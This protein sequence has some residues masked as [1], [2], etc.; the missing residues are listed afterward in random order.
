[1]ECMSNVQFP[2]GTLSIFN[3]SGLLP[4]PT[5]PRIIGRYLFDRMRDFGTIRRFLEN[6]YYSS[7]AYDDELVRQIRACTEGSGGHAAFASIMWSPPVGAVKVGVGRHTVR[8]CLN[9]SAFSYN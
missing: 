2:I 9:I 4:A 8:V 6:S 1:M 5:V 3:R 7:E